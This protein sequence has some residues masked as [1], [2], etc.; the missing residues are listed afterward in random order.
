MK[1][2]G[3][4][5]VYHYG[6]LRCACANR[7]NFLTDFHQNEA[8]ILRALKSTTLLISNLLSMAYVLLQFFV[9]LFSLPHGPPGQEPATLLR[10]A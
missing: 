1:H 8:S 9:K 7:T 5:D 6:D 4:V 10:K 2:G 3:P